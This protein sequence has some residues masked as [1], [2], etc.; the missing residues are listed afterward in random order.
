MAL[1]MTMPV[2]Q[3]PPTLECPLDGQLPSQQRNSVENQVFFLS[4]FQA[5][6][7]TKGNMFEIFNVESSNND[8]GETPHYL[9]GLTLSCSLYP[10]SFGELHDGFTMCRAGGFQNQEVRALPTR[11][12]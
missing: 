5:I 3:K 12:R 8:S 1:S 7:L 9:G 11:T 10:L 4:G 6:E 2:R